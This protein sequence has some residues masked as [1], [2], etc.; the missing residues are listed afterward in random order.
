MA[1]DIRPDQAAS[2]AAKAVQNGW[3]LDGVKDA[4]AM[5]G[6]SIQEVILMAL[7]R[8]EDANW[9]GTVFE[10]PPIRKGDHAKKI[11]Q[12]TDMLDR[13]A[14]VLCKISNGDTKAFENAGR[15]AF[16]AALLLTRIGETAE[17]MEAITD[18]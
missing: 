15:V 7:N 12:L 3:D 18:D 14:F 8:G 13:C 1:T 9:L 6:T 17:W 16:D 5:P 4:T 10:V 11:R 2:L